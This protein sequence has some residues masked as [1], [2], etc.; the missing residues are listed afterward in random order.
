M[1]DTILVL[2]AGSSSI[3]FSLFACDD[4]DLHQIYRGSITGIGSRAEFTVKHTQGDILTQQDLGEIQHEAAFNVLLSW[5]SQHEDGLNLISVGHRVVHGGVMFTEPTVIDDRI[6]RQLDSL[7]PLAPLHQPHNILPIK[8]LR[9]LNPQLQQVACFDTAF[10]AEQPEVEQML[11]IPRNYWESGI[12]RYGFH[13]S[14]Y[15][16]ITSILPKIVGCVPERLV[17]A[18]LGNGASLAAVSNAVGVATTM[19]FTPLDGVPMGTRPGA[20]DAGVILYLLNNGM[21]VATLNHFLYHECGLLGVSGISNDMQT[22]LASDTVEARQAIDLFS[23]RVAREIGSL[24][25]A[26][27]GLE[28]LVFTGGIGEHAPLIREKVCNYL[29]WMGINLDLNANETN[30]LQIST[31]NSKISVWVI[32]TDEEKMIAQHTY[33]AY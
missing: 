2:N 18:H 8:I 15:E 4:G 5:I 1:T 20:L 29:T 12:K 26:L 16:Y 21:D 23:Y 22:L 9:K 25:V 32:P 7:I 31:P 10:H 30:N 27:Q 28:V 24:A 3:K 33:E 6:I 19:S 11:P 17:I 13:G 14:S